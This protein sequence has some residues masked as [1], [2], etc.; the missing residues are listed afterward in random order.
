M[1]RLMDAVK[2]YH[3]ASPRL[4]GSYEFQMSATNFHEVF[5]WPREYGK[6]DVDVAGRWKEEEREERERKGMKE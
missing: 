4:K 3:H 5:F 2:N 6:K 1:M